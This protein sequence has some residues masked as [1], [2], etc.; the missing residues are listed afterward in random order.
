[1]AGFGVAV[2]RDGE[3][4]LELARRIRPAAI[5]LDI[6]LPKLDGWD[7]LARAK[8]DPLLAAI[9]VVIV[10]MIDQ[11]GRGFALGAADYLV[12]PVKREELLAA[13][14]RVMP[15]AG[16]QGKPARVLAIDDDPLAVEL[17]EAVLAPRGYQVLKAAD[18]QT[19]L[20]LAR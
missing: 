2:A 8:A 14:Q 6:S 10:S 16:D 20:E 19:G 5:S 11:R 3:A 15:A 7:F 4:G 18:G 9:P 13:L 12:K 17:I 1:R